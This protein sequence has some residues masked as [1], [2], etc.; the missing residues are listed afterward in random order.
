MFMFVCKSVCVFLH[1][2]RAPSTK[3]TR[4]LVS[5]NQVVLMDNNT[6]IRSDGGLRRVE[7]GNRKVNVCVWE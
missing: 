2:H 7:W 6:V 4:R 5:D 1:L 3:P